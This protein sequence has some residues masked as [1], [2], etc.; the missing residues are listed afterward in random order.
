MN[1]KERQY[2]R[3]RLSGALKALGECG[4]EDYEKYIVRDVESEDDAYYKTLELMRHKERPTGMYSCSMILW[5]TACTGEL[6]KAG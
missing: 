1:D 2:N 5:L 6:P 3:E 4:I